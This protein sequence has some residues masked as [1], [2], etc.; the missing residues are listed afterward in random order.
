[1]R[2]DIGWAY[3]WSNR[4]AE[5]L[6]LLI[7]V[8]EQAFSRPPVIASHALGLAA[9]V[10]YQTGDRAGREELLGTLD[11][12]KEPVP[13]PPDWRAGHD[14]Q[15]RVWIRASMDPFGK[16]A[17]TIPLLHRAADRIVDD[18]TGAMGAIG[19]AAWLLDDTELAVRLMRDALSSLRAPGMRAGSGGTLSALQWACIDSG[20]WDEALAIA[21]EAADT[22]AAY[23]MEAVAAS[24]DLG[25]ATVLAMRG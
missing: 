15:R 4:Q 19:A 24:A 12:L 3:V 18:Q 16:R 5:A 25:T 21:P 10:A 17:E 11:G 23:R 7:A 14:D 22:A 1:A 8:A 9:T 13:L 2:L 6:A 20:R